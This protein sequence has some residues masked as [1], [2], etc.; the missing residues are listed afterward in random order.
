M[1][2][3]LID[4][5]AKAITPNWRTASRN[6]R[7]NARITVRAALI[8]GS[9]PEAPDDDMLDRAVRVASA[10]GAIISQSQAH[11]IWQAMYDEWLAGVLGS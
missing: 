10:T 5:A 2:D 6:E 9:P 1:N 3:S 11:D 4:R 7:E 8:A